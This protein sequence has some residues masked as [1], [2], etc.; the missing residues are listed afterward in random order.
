MAAG[1]RRVGHATLGIGIT[2]AAGPSASEGH[3][4]GT[5]FVA[6]ADEKRVWGKSIRVDGAA[7]GRDKV[8]RLAVLQALDLA[9]RY[10]E[11]WPTVMAGGTPILPPEEETSLPPSAPIKKRSWKERLL[12]TVKNGRAANFRL[13]AMWV[14]AVLGLAAVIWLSV[15]YLL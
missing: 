12:P 13:L 6:M 3:P 9:R 2:G 11:A 1:V 14:F 15:L 4:A 5:V 8:R 7:L 10:L